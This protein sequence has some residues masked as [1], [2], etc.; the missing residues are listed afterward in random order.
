MS[1]GA[2]LGRLPPRG[3]AAEMEARVSTLAAAVAGA[4]YWE[5]ELALSRAPDYAVY[6]L[7]LALEVRQRLRQ[8]LDQEPGR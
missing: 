6:K 8:V 3:L 4:E 7:G 2:D 5:M 1:A